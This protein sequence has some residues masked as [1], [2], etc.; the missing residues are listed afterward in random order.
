MPP[1]LR[2]IGAKCTIRRNAPV[3]GGS[4]CSGAPLGGPATSAN[5]RADFEQDTGGLVSSRAAL[6]RGAKAAALKKRTRI[7]DAPG[8][9]GGIEGELE[10]DEKETR[11][12]AKK[13]KRDEP[14]ANSGA[15]KIISAGGSQKHYGENIVCVAFHFEVRVYVELTSASE[16]ECNARAGKD[17]NPR[18][19]ALAHG[20]EDMGRS[21]SLDKGFVA[22]GKVLQGIPGGHSASFDA[23]DDRPQVAN[24]S[25]PS[26]AK[27]KRR[28]LTA[29]TRRYSYSSDISGTY[30][31]ND[32]RDPNYVH[33]DS[34][35]M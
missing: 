16:D 4:A 32:I 1:N 18:L 2:I 6:T 27:G 28:A 12:I 23:V 35:D 33:D 24:K 5:H 31:E 25:G 26:K 11:H 9:G 30:T 19:D 21:D 14:G 15:P 8:G 34:D 10:R 22:E 20:E 29:P 7:V 17:K 13:R 3:S